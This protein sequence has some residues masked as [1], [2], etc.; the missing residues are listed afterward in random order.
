MEITILSPGQALAKAY[1]HQLGFVLCSV[2]IANCIL[3]IQNP[4][5]VQYTSNLLRVL[6]LEAAEKCKM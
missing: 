2:E 3:Q 5:C 4:W 6:I 1:V